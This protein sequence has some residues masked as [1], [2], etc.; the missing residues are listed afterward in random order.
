MV[1]IIKFSTHVQT[2]GHF[3]L[4]DKIGVGSFGTVWMARDTEL[5]RV[6]AIAGSP[7]MIGFQLLMTGKLR[8]VTA[9]GDYNHG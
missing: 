2:I 8:M 6:S 9:L 1:Q 5:D 7:P 4:V 3:E